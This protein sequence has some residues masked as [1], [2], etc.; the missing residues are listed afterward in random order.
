[1][2]TFASDSESQLNF[3]PAESIV[4]YLDKILL[5]EMEGAFI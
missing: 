2:V 5:M 3:I 1:M 4:Y